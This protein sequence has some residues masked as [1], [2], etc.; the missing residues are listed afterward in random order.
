MCTL[1]GSS[2]TPFTLVNHTL[3]APQPETIVQHQG[4]LLS[5]TVLYFVQHYSSRHYHKDLHIAHSNLQHANIL[6]KAR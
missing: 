2:D 6:Y 4:R 5:Y 3:I 1:L